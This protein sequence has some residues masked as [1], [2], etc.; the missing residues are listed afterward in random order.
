M[1]FF[2]L[3]E[4]TVSVFLLFHGSRIFQY[5]AKLQEQKED[6]PSAANLSYSFRIHKLIFQ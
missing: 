3:T 2:S 4:G 6:P 5:K 1:F